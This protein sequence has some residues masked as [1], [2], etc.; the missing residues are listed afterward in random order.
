M[1]AAG[2]GDYL[3]HEQQPDGCVWCTSRENEAP[4]LDPDLPRPLICEPKD[5]DNCVEFC[6]TVTPECALPWFKATTCL[7]GSEMAYRLAIFNRETADRPEVVLSGRVVDEGGK[8]VEKARVHVWLAR[9]TALTPLVDDTTGKDGVFRIK[10]RTGPW[11]YTLR[12]SAPGFATEI[13]ER[14]AADRLDLKPGSPPR[15]FR[16]APEQAIRGRVVD[17]ALGKPV[18]GAKVQAMRN[19]E[20]AVEVAE[21]TTG[22][23]GGFV[24]AGLEAK[25]YH[26]RVSRFGWRLLAPAAPVAAPQ[27]RVMVKMSRGNVI[28]GL[29]VD[30]DG[31]PEPNAV[32]A[33]VLSGLPGPIIWRADGEGRFAQDPFSAGTYYLWARRRDLLA[34][35]P[36]KI[37]LGANQQEVELKLTL[38]HKGARVSGRVRALQ[39]VALGGD[40]RVVLLAR[41]PLAFPRPAVGDIDG[42]GKFVVGG[43]SPGRY[44]LAVRRGSRDM[45][46]V[47][48][49]RGVEIPIEPGST[50]SLDE[51]LTVRPQ[52]EE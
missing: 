8:R 46:I 20:D 42:E 35:P 31:E 38:K 33:A 37:E 18:A 19:S 32:V 3:C 41:S 40:A 30:A 7:L 39:G 49:P 4:Y 25:R 5:P 45:V 36:E 9:G 24:L 1:V 17:A 6:S 43:L 29:V 2:R 11:T 21:A 48:G 13:V 51:P 26:L 28:R 34:Y 16:L 23:D 15:S 14:L 27:V 50:V 12:L 22:D 47:S 44:A 10:L 52:I